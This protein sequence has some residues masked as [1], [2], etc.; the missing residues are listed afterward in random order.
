MATTTAYDAEHQLF[1]LRDRHGARFAASMDDLENFIHDN[2]LTAAIYALQIGASVA[3]LI[4]LLILTKPEKRR[5]PVFFLNS[6]ALFFNTIAT[7]LL[8]VYWLGPWRDALTYLS[9]DYTQSTIPNSAVAQ[10]IVSTIFV[11]AVII[12]LEISLVLQVQVV[13]VTLPKLRRVAILS[14]SAIVAGV[15]IITY[16]VQTAFRI[17]V[18]Q[19][20]RSANYASV[21]ERLTKARD[22]ALASS[23]CFF[24]VCFCLK[25]GWSMYRRHKLG[26]RQFGPMQII[27]IGGTQTM[28]IPGSLPFLLRFAPT[29]TC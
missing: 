3:V 20:D 16:I 6:L 10:S 14:V 18:N 25:L 9:A 5:S 4:M 26:I 15:A 19:L 7:T 17:R 12:C 11:M 13:C 27:L 21:T 29:R 28:I 2:T 24:S 8:C 23:I 1:D 22:I